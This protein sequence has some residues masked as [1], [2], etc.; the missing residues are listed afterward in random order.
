MASTAVAKSILLLFLHCHSF[1]RFGVKRWAESRGKSLGEV[2]EAAKANLA[3]VNNITRSVS[4]MI[5]LGSTRKADG[6]ADIEEG[7]PKPVPKTNSLGAKS[8]NKMVG[9]HNLFSKFAPSWVM[10]GSEGRAEA[11][12]AGAWVGNEQIEKSPSTG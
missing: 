11:A 2:R 12:P 6:E 5:G 10:R 3:P 4:T 8:N 1:N 7:K 9:A